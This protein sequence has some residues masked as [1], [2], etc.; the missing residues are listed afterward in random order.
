MIHQ[1]DTWLKQDGFL[2]GKQMENRKKFLKSGRFVGRV[3]AQALRMW[4]CGNQQI[5][6]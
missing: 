5:E 3:K 2:A 4:K 6:N 1:C